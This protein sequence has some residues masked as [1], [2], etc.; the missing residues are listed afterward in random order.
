LR[1]NV[2]K[3]TTDSSASLHLLLFTTRLYCC[4]NKK[5]FFRCSTCFLALN[6][7]FYKASQYVHQLLEGK[8]CLSKVERH[9][10]IAFDCINLYLLH[11][12]FPS[13][14]SHIHFIASA[15]YTTVNTPPIKF[16]TCYS[17][18]ALSADCLFILYSF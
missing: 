4:N 8:R 10:Q 6:Y 13:L 3:Y 14:N 7:T 16:S 15:N 12:L 1:H 2:A 9:A 17:F 11:T 18:S 5:T